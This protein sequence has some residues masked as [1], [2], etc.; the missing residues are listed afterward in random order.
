MYLYD[1]TVINHV[2][3]RLLG[4]YFWL[5]GRVE[6]ACILTFSI[7]LIALFVILLY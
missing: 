5:R 7:G 1:A 2:R 4:S 6:R 3:P